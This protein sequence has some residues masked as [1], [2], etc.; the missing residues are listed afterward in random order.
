MRP[1]KLRQTITLFL[2]TLLALV[3][4][5]GGEGKEIALTLTPIAALLVPVLRFYFPRQTR[6]ARG[7]ADS[8]GIPTV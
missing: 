4:L 1:A 8:A 6:A 2:L 5:R 7:N 3:A